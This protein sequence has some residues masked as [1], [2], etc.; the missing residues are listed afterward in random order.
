[1]RKLALGWMCGAALGCTAR[2]VAPSADAGGPLD[3]AD[4]GV[5]RV[6]LLITLGSS[7]TAGTGASTEAQRYTNLLAAA[8][9]ARLI[10][11]GSGGQTVTQVAQTVLPAALQVL[12]AGMA[13][14]GAVHALTFL[15]LTDFA[16]LS[17]AQLRDGYAPIL[18]A[19]DSTHAWVFFGIPSVDA[20][21]QCGAAGPLRGPHGECYDAALV[22]DYAAKQDVM[23]ALVR[24]H[25]GMRVA[26]IPQTFAQHPDWQQPDGHPTNA[27]HAFIAQCFYFSLAARLGLDAGPPPT[28]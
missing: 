19:L 6:D 24:A 5:A 27:G 17:A 16:N 8:L 4:A 22:A 2:S 13:A 7:S 21:Y 3:P 10:N 20:L 25:P 11:L 12:D 26:E 1:M 23:S 15:P 28:P 14:Q 9:G 18:D